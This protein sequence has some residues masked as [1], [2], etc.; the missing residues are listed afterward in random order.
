MARAWDPISQTWVEGV[1]PSLPDAV[2]S[3]SASSDMSGAGGASG[4]PPETPSTDMTGGAGYVPPPSPTTQQT[5]TPQPKTAAPQSG[6]V[7]QADGRVMIGDATGGGSPAQPPQ[8]LPPPG[9]RPGTPGRL[10]PGGRTPQSWQVS[11]KAGLDLP[12]ELLSRMDQADKDLDAAAA[13]AT[14]AERRKSDITAE[15]KQQQAQTQMLAQEQA[16][17]LQAR[18][19]AQIDDAKAKYDKAAQIDPES[20]WGDKSGLGKILASIAVGIGAFVQGRTGQP[21]AVL[22]QINKEI[23]RDVQRQ[24]GAMNK[25]GK[26]I[27]DFYAQYD[28]EDQKIAAG[29]AVRLDQALVHLDDMLSGVTD[30][31][32]AAQGLELRAKLEQEAIDRKVKLA[33]LT[34][35][36]KMVQRHDV[37]TPDRVAGGSPGG[38]DW[39]ATLAAMRASGADLE[40][41]QK[42]VNALKA[43]GHLNTDQAMSVIASTYGVRPVVDASKQTGP[44]SPATFVAD[45]FGGE[46]G[47]APDADTARKKS[48]QYR[49]YRAIQENLQRM[50]ELRGKSFSSFGDTARQYDARANDVLALYAVA[51]GQGALSEG[52]RETM[53][54]ILGMNANNTFTFSGKAQLDEASNIIDRRLRGL[55]AGIV[56]G[57]QQV[58]GGQVRGTVT[59]VQGPRVDARTVVARKPGER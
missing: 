52:D 22:D 55:D 26:D 53:G 31:T 28:R 5:D 35:G 15:F 1:S 6:V 59:G 56:H 8:P 23:E 20:W 40:Q 21:N 37:M 18:R 48:E 11:Q 13:L 32:T 39:T 47:F 42:D 29:E 38:Y 50:K 36:E 2:A 46:G 7:G 57:K 49:A 14:D 58:S 17:Q 19:D 27:Q 3:S 51:N 24:I 34:Q 54:K 45:A 10:V 43:A 30:Q 33:G 16:S 44:G 12:P 41:V 9:Y 25:A 4:I